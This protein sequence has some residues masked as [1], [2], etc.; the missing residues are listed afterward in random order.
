MQLTHACNSHLPWSIV[1]MSCT[2]WPVPFFTFIHLFFLWSL[3][4]RSTSKAP[5]KTVF[6]KVSCWVIW[7]NQ[8]S[9]YC[10]TVASRGSLCPTS[11]V[12]M[13]QTMFFS[14]YRQSPHFPSVKQDHYNEGLVQTALCS[15]PNVTAVPYPV[16]PSHC[17]CCA[18]ETV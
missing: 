15:K 11:M 2:R 4:H 9:L 17:R 16:Q 3:T 8:V 10:F 6:D 13:L 1:S 5:W 14:P 7:P 18:L 12:T